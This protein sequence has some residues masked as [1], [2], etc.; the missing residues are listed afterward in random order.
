M[1]KF[2]TNIHKEAEHL[3]L[4]KAEK[5]AMLASVL[6][7][8]SPVSVQ[9]SPYVFLTYFNY[10]VRMVMAGFVFFIFAGLSTVSAAQG[11]LPGD[12]LYPVK[13]SINENIEMAFASDNADKAA[14]EVRLAERRVEEA[15][16]LAAQGRLDAKAADALAVSFDLHAE[17]AQ[18]LADASEESEPGI[19]EQ[20]K[21][22]LSATFAVHGA[23]LKNLGKVSTDN[24]TK[25][26]SDVF[27]DRVLARADGPKKVAMQARTFA[28]AP[29]PDVSKTKA[30]ASLE[31]NI[32]SV[33]TA[34]DSQNEAEDSGAQKRAAGL[35]KKATE[36]LV[37]TRG[38]FKSVGEK[39]DATTTAQIEKVFA[40]MDLDM[41]TGAEAFGKGSFLQAQESFTLVLQ[42]S[43]KLQ[44]LLKAEKRFDNGILRQLI[45]TEIP[46][47]V[48]SPGTNIEV[49]FIPVEKN[50]PA[51]KAETSLNVPQVTPSAPAPSV[52]VPSLPFGL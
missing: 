28:A 24:D 52:T 39:M 1:K 10:E 41:S 9:K 42:T 2:L 18:S 31:V 17:N 47:S 3:R 48:G 19:S 44:A 12:L 23:V 36:S 7:V 50:I 33:S 27:G 51:P 6:G 40:Q 25:E 16:T 30:S 34:N 20:V 38:L 11:S 15:Q 43:N 37:E 21:T 8:Q 13:L 5:S 22:K 14:L 46:A 4:S 32:L 35:Q 29:A 26:Q 49:R 45:Q